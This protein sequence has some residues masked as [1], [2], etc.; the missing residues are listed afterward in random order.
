MSRPLVPELS[1]IPISFE[2]VEPH[3]DPS[4]QN[5]LAD[6]SLPA[7]LK[8]WNS[9]DIGRFISSLGFPQYSELFVQSGISG[10]QFA[11]LTTLDLKNT[12]KVQ[13][14]GDRKRIRSAIDQKLL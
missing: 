9:A 6:S 7:D 4:Q 11:A 5:I 8:E 3:E 10:E 14:L 1:A 2:N 12:F 13:S